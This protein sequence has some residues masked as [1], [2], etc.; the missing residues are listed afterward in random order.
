M[1][2][3]GG[4]QGQIRRR[5]RRDRDRQGDNGSRGGRRRRARPRSSCPKAPQDVP[6]N[7]ADRDACRR[8]RGRKAAGAAGAAPTAKADAKP[9]TRLRSR[10]RKPHRLPPARMAAAARTAGCRNV[11]AAAASASQWR[12]RAS[13]PRRWRAA[14]RRREGSISL[15]IQGSGPHGR[16][17]AARRRR[18]PEGGTAKSRAGCAA[19]HPGAP[20]R[21]AP[22]G[23]SDEQ[24]KKLFEP[25][26]YE[27]VP[28]DGMRKII[29][30]RLTEA[31]QTI[32]HF[33]L[34]VDCEIDALLDAARADQRRGAKGQRRQAGLQGLGQ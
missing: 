15:R 33:Y 30:R 4:R 34:T 21:T 27:V 26:S 2:E 10:R 5:H 32:P 19:A 9:K 22:A 11:R 24:V 13:S 7:D 18:R 16:I 28:H 14:W 17:V 23:M 8:R 29:A 31:K 20:R 25:G 12:R 6:V 1:A 3:E